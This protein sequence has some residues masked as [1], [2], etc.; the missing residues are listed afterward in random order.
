MLKK[1]FRDYSPKISAKA[2]VAENATVIG[3]VEIEDKVSVWYGV[4][5]R[6]DSDL[7]SIG[8]GSNVQDNSTLHPDL[9]FPVIIGK[10]VTI[11]H[12]AVIHGCTIKNDVLIGMGAIVLNGAIIEEGAV[13]AAGSVVG[14]NVIVPKNTL[15]IGNPLVIKGEIKESLK[16]SIKE[17]NDLYI[18]YGNYYLNN[19]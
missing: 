7:I 14:S 9:G 13:V 3:N 6:G 18:E 11:G 1:N 10:N 19:E 15:A 2:F 17:G 8:E 12:N 4:V 5:L 16:K